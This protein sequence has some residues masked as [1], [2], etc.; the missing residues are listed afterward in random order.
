MG[1]RSGQTRPKRKTGPTK[2]SK[3]KDRGAEQLAA[4]KKQLH[5]LVNKCELIRVGEGPKSP[6]MAAVSEAMYHV[7]T[8]NFNNRLRF[9]A[10][11]NAK[12]VVGEEKK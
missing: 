9:E 2:P 12:M 4:F 7:V 1:R 6:S 10:M 3:P 8:Q 5:D 11:I